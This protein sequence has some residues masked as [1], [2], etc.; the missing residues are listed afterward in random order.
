MFVS[1]LLGKTAAV[2]H[3]LGCSTWRSQWLPA[4]RI[5]SGTLIRESAFGPRG[6]FAIYCQ[7]G[8]QENPLAAAVSRRL[9]LFSDLYLTLMPSYIYLWL[10]YLANLRW[11]R[12]CPTGIHRD[13]YP[14]HI[15]FVHEAL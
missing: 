5:R 7:P 3:S 1:I 12:L 11:V 2:N 9:S 13:Q 4:L 15:V 14:L 8:F 10:L 6:G